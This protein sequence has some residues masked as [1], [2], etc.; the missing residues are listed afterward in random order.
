V[1]VLRERAHERQVDVDVRVD[2]AWEH[3]L[4][5]CINHLRA[6]RRRDVPVEARDR[7]AFAENV[8][9]VTFAGRDD[10]TVLDE[11]THAPR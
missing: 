2:E 3:E 6:T 9:H 8:G 11:Q 1:R 4:A 10:L 7:F 5:A